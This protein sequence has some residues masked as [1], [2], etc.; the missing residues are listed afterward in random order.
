MIDFSF[1]P[2]VEEIRLKVRA[3]M[4]DVVRPEWE[5]IDQG[6]RGEVIKAIVKLRRIARED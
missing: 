1:P 2:E 3:L 6:Q 4:D 5:A